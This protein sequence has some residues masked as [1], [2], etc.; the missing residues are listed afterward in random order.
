M[1]YKTQ[2]VVLQGKGR[3]TTYWL[4]G[5][6][7]LE[8]NNEAGGLG[9]GTENAVVQ[10]STQLS[11]PQ[12][13]EQLLSQQANAPSITRELVQDTTCTSSVNPVS[14]MVYESHSEFDMLLNDFK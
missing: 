12:Q 7:N 5:E 4:L 3:M 9:S 2:S 10:N 6:K 13:L 8:A 11:Q 1:C 14:S